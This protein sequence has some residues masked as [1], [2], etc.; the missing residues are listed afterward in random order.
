MH[1]TAH[2]SE[3]G[4]PRSSTLEDVTNSPALKPKTCKLEPPPIW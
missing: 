4:A 2:A 1:K 3:I